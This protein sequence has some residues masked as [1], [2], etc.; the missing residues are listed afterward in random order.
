[1]RRWPVSQL[2]ARSDFDLSST[3]TLAPLA[4]AV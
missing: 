2:F 4:A 1:M 3:W